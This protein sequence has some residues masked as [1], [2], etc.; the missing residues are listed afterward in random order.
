LRSG[1]VEEDGD[2]ERGMD[3][4]EVEAEVGEGS[5]GPGAG[6]SVRIYKVDQA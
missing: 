2:A 6:L 4:E 5:D 3:D 1:G